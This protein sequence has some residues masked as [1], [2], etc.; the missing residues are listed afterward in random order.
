[1]PRIR[2]GRH[3]MKR[4]KLTAAFAIIGLAAIGCTATSPISFPSR[5]G[6][7]SQSAGDGLENFDSAL[8]RHSAVPADIEPYELATN[9]TLTRHVAL[10]T[11]GPN[12]NLKDLVDNAPGV[13]LIDFYADWCGPCGTQG[14]ILHELEGVA[15]QHNA[16][17]IKVNV[18]VHRGL[19]SQLQVSSLPTLML[20]KDGKLLERRMGVADRQTVSGLLQR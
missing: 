11:L 9:D 3:N 13:V 14:K 15:A 2:N 7:S 8:A 1:M 17:I 19:A 4:I 18:D 16:S 12:E 6:R 10:K 20:I 5:S